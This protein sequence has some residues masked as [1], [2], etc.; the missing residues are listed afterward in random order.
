M[1]I[2]TIPPEKYMVSARN[3]ETNFLARKSGRLSVNASMAELASPRIVP[4]TV[5]NIEILKP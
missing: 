3:T 1:Y 4:E 5:R 2:G